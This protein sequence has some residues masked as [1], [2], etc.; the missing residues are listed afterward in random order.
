MG[1]A[2]EKGFHSLVEVLLSNGAPPDSRALWCAVR[3]RRR[4]ILDL[5]FTYGADAKSVRFEHVISMSDPHIIR[6]FVDAGADIVTD[7]PLAT[8][9]IQSPHAFLRLCKELLPSQ[10]ELMFQVNMALRHFSHKGSMRGVSL[11]LWLG[12]NPRAKVPIEP[13]EEQDMWETS[14][15]SALYNGQ[16]EIVKK[17]GLDPANDDIQEAFKWACHSSNV[18]L[19]KYVGDLGADP[20]RVDE[21]EHTPLDALFW[22]LSLKFDF[23][24]KYE[25]LQCLQGLVKSGIKWT[26][27][28]A[29]EVTKLRS[30][31]YKL[32]LCELF[33]LVKEMKEQLFCTDEV[34][35]RLLDTAKMRQLVEQRIPALATLL[36]YFEKWTPSK[37]K[38]VR[39]KREP[40]R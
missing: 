13:T 16:L 25:A 24:S 9:L 10:P 4:E 35:I 1:I 37:A 8:G 21:Q 26:P 18:S 22:H 23:G 40:A 6:M 38:R 2:I 39:K 19:M 36:P 14:L 33:C 7:Y 15:F 30:L 11:M 31:F 27:V 34:M 12:A 5:L 32:A 28:S 29:D 3:W 20:K 17:L